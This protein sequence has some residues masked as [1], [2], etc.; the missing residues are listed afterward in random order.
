MTQKKLLRPERRRQVPAQFSWLDHRL[1]RDHRLAACDP[2]ALALYLVL[3]T[4]ADAQGLSYYSE[5]S[6]ARLIH[7]TPD[8]VIGARQQLVAADLI[9]YPKPLYQVLSLESIP[10]GPRANLTQSAGQ[11][12]RQI[13]GGPQ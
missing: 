8:Q 3:V 9:A 10:A 7:L 12:L 4:V 1:V 11:I 13:L 2:S 5:A 6:L